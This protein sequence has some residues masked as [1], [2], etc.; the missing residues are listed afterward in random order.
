MTMMIVVTT[1]MTTTMSADGDGEITVGITT[2]DGGDN[3]HA[4]SVIYSGRQ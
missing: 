1:T 2:A 4:F 3:R